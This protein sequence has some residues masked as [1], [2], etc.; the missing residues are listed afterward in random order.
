MQPLLHGA[1]LIFAG[2][3]SLYANLAAIVAIQLAVLFLGV[4][5]FPADF[6]SMCH[7]QPIG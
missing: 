5:S 7:F 3:G 2:I 1:A 4:D 6:R